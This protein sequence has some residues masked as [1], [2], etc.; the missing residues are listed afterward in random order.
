MARAW[1]MAFYVSMT[2]LVIDSGCWESLGAKKGKDLENEAMEGEE[3]SVLVVRGG[4]AYDTPAFEKM[5]LSLEGLRVDLVL[6]SHMYQMKTKDILAKYDAI[7]FLNYNSS[8]PEH[9]WNKRKYLEI[10]D[11]GVGMVFLHFTLAS[12]PGWTE[13]HD[14][15]GG[16]WFYPNYAEDASQYSSLYTDVSV[17]LEVVNPDH[18]VT[19]GLEN[20]VLTDAFYG[21]IYIAPEAEPLLETQHPNVS[22][23]IA[24][25]HEYKHAKIVYIMPGFTAKAYENDSYR[26]LI[27]NSLRY[28]GE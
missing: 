25:T 19:Q 27:A 18:P 28:V 4:H 11:A 20:F 1:T 24:W 23:T 2:I 17:E 12:Q 5:C 10:A 3:Q 8:C 6:S 7:L 21:N 16:E 26:R 9:E 22:R 14:M 15:V 13:Y